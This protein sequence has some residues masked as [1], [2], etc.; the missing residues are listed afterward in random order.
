M[1]LSYLGVLLATTVM[2]AAPAAMAQN[3]GAEGESVAADNIVVTATRR[4]TSLQDTPLAVNVVTSEKLQQLKIFDIKDISSVAPGLELTNTQGRN[5]V[6]TLRGINFN[7]DAG[8]QA[9]VDVFLNE[10]PADAQTVF[11]AI[12]DLGQIEVLRGPQGLFRGRTSPA[13]S[14]LIGTRKANV[15]DFEGYVQGTMS[16]QHAGNFQG[17]A[18]LPIVPGRLALRTALLYD[19]NAGA[20]VTNIDGSRTDNKTISGRASL[21]YRDEALSVDLAYQYLNADN[22]PW[23]A[24]F[25]PGRQPSTASPARSGPPL[26]LDDRTSVTEGANRFQNETHFLTLNAR[27]DLGAAQLVFNGG[28]QHTDLTQVRDLDVTNAVPGEQRTQAIA[29]TY[30]VWNG[31]LRL[32]SSPGSPL[33]WSASGVYQK[34]ETFTSVA[35]NNDGYF[36]NATTPTLPSVRVIRQFVTQ[37]IDQS[38]EQYGFAGTVGYKFADAVTVT[39]G[40]RHMWYSNDK[41]TEQLITR[42]TFV[43]NVRNG[44]VLVIGPT[45]TVEPTRRQKALTGGANINWEVTPDLNVYASYSHSFRPGVRAAVL[46]QG[47]PSALG[48]VPSETS[49]GGEIGFKSTL[50]DRKLTLNAAVFYQKY[51]N[52]ISFVSGVV[53]DTDLNGIADTSGGANVPVSGKASSRGVEAELGFRPNRNIDLSV[54]A[55]YADTH[56]DGATI[57]CNDFNRDGVPDATGAPAVQT[58]QVISSCTTNDRIAQVPRFSLSANGEIRIP[59]GSDL[60]PFLRGL[61][62]Y[63]PGFTSQADSYDYSAF[64]KVDLFVGLRGG[65]AWEVTAFVKNLLDQTRALSV[66]QGNGQVATVERI[67]NVNTG[68][69]GVPWDSGYRTAS[70]TP[71]REFGVSL[72]YRW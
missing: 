68:R 30:K 62:N 26:T 21:A 3:A 51:D 44:A 10:I 31:E 12:Y 61:V 50:F 18:N 17:A 65:K 25:G 34:N 60:Q 38:A 28:Y 1:K 32:E 72:S 49:D 33:I 7:P 39:G 20:G 11:T 54:N 5:N 45:T 43:N 57:F 29:P 19:Y 41:T 24:A 64:T 47:F 55:A 52:F 66:S 16:D 69:A 6:A 4:D 42:A 36:S 27:Y 13:G 56:W 35:Q 40:L 15:D 58:G 37:G 59:T 53:V 46:P 9:A 14:I 63:R 48:E 67:G 22:R 71:P 2:T 8:G 70:I 23:I